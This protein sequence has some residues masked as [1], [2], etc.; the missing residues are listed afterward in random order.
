MSAVVTTIALFPTTGSTGPEGTGPDGQL[1]I[2]SNG[3]LLGATVLGGA[4]GHGTTYEI[5]KIAGGYASTPTF[6]ADIPDGLNTLANVPNLSADANGDLFGLMITGG[7]NSLGTVVEFPAGGGAATTLVNFSGTG[8]S[9]PAGQLLVDP[10]GNLFGITASGGANGAGTV[11]EVQKVGGVYATTPTTLTSFAAGITPSGSGN[12]VEDAAG[13]LF[14]T[15][16]SSVFEVTK[17]GSSYGAPT[18][19]LSIPFPV[20]TQIGNLTIDSKGDIFGTTISGGAND[21]GSVFEIEKTA[22]GYVS[23]AAILASFTLADGQL[24]LNHTKTLIVDANGD[25]FGTTDPSTGN[26]GGVVYEIVKTPTGYNSTPTIVTN[27]AAGAGFGGN[28]VADASGDLFTTTKAG[29]AGSNGSVLEITGSGFATTPTITPIL[30]NIVWQNTS[31]Q[32]ALWQIDGTSVIATAVVGANPGPS[33]TLVGTGDFSGDGPSD[34]LWQNA[35]GQAAI[36]QTNGTNV[37]ATEL[38]GSNPGPSWRLVGTGDFSGVSGDE[39]SDLVWQNTNG[40]AAIWDM[41]GTSV[42]A[43]EVV[44]PNP[45]PNWRLVGTGDFNGN[46]QSDLLWQN[47]STGQA[48]IWDMSG[49]N[50]TST[51]VVAGDPGP[52]WKLV[53]TGDFNGDGMS[54]LLWQNTNGQVATWQMNGFNVTSAGVVAD[55]G[56]TW[57]AIGTGAGGSDILLQNTSGQAAIWEM[58]GSTMTGGSLVNPSPGPTWRAVGLT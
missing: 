52:S 18:S 22:T 8:S 3:D 24:S 28:L 27:G 33:W 5:A 40:Q 34:F 39:Q 7:A 44:G 46:G 51:A 54:D 58:S 11:F 47:V 2:D 38:V 55:P 30:S 36:W 45:G 29:G 10:S 12:L 35:S 20:G 49:T 23:A 13:D 26:A 56:P 9:Q 4:D 14:G 16:T 17:T 15:T 50:V 32:A 43:T 21:D 57:T 31:G 48:A 42:S 53:G 19:L 37:T 1:F 6:L 41:N 25:L